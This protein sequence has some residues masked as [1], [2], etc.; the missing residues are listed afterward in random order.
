MLANA[1]ICN[2]VAEE[3]HGSRKYHQAG[4]LL[5]NKVLVGNLFRLTQY[6]SCY[7]M[8][9][10]KGCYN[11]IDHILLSLSWCFCIKTS[12]GVSQP[13]YGNKDEDKPIARIGQGDGLG[14]SLWCLISTIIIKTCKRKGHRIIITT[15][16]SKKEVSLLGFAFV[17]DADLVTTANNAYT[18][19]MEMINKM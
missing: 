6:S 7:A 8:N 15:P 19:S 5:L 1:E 2:E 16:I 14:P 10:A 9:D 12:Y 18:S 11:R 17:D 3:Q 4:L 13:V